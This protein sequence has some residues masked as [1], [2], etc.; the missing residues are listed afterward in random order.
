MIPPDDLQRAQALHADLIRTRRALSRCEFRLSE[1]LIQL[2]RH[3]SAQ[4]LG[5]SG[6]LHYALVEL[7]LTERQTVEMLRLG[8]RLVGLPVL[9]AAFEEG[10]LGWTKAREV[11]RVATEKT[12]AGWVER[13][14]AVPSRELERQVA[15][16]KPGDA[17]PDPDSVLRP[18]RRRVSFDMASTDA[19][20]LFRALAV[21]R[22]RGEYADG[23]A[24]DGVLLADMAR[25]V[26][27]DETVGPEAQPDSPAPAER[28]RIVL[29]RCPDC[30]ATRS[31]G[32]AVDPAVQA[33]AA[34]DAE[35]MS[36]ESG[37][38]GHVTRTIPPAT[39][40]SVMASHHNR[41]AVPWF[42]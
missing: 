20:L 18:A 2:D 33:E 4:L 37:R 41:C 32:A 34:C 23:E 30:S 6:T 22:V 15:A 9:R 25:R 5:Y 39:R 21:L 12:E 35:V 26:L 16:C 40:R 3:G 38:R 36:M 28:Y 29:E 14:L 31:D 1:L 13:A 11:A 27:S 19:E 8:G 17:P 7:D 24:D 10:R 42:M